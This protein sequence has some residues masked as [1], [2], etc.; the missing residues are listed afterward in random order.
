MQ[1]NLIHSMVLQVL[2]TA[3][4]NKDDK[5]YKINLKVVKEYISDLDMLKKEIVSGLV[6]RLK[7]KKSQAEK[8][9][10]E[11]TFAEDEE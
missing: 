1:D 2:D 11:I 5:D 3:E 10:G 4:E 8:M 7:I 9:L 6:R